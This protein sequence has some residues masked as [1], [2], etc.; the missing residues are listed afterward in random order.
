MDNGA[1]LA[2]MIDAET[3]T[4]DVYRPGHETVMVRDAA[5]IE[6]TDPVQGFVLDLSRVWHSIGE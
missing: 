6:A 5:T 4:V 3:K 1:Q 2:W